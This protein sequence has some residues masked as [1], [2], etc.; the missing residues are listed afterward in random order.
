TYAVV[1]ETVTPYNTA[2]K[3]REVQYAHTKYR[4]YFVQGDTPVQRLLCSADFTN[5]QF[6]AFTFGVNPNDE[7]GSTPNVALTPSGTEVGKVISL[8]ASSFPNWSNTET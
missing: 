5:W 2:Q 1:Y 8:T 6:A 7:L 3:V 4:M